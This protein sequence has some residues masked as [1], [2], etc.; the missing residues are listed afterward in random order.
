M[1][2]EIVKSERGVELRRHNEDGSITI[3]LCETPEAALFQA[4][5]L[6]YGRDPDP[7]RSILVGV[8]VKKDD[9]RITMAE[10]AEALKKKLAE[11][12][13]ILKP[14]DVNPFVGQ[15]LTVPYTQP[16]VYPDST[17]GPYVNPYV[18][19][20]GGSTITIIPTTWTTTTT[21]SVGSSSAT[22]T[23]NNGGA[24]GAVFGYAMASSDTVGYVAMNIASLKP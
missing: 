20:T 4:A 2:I 12:G 8:F 16:Y 5:S 15:P 14:A 11:D 1:K 6:L 13:I 10:Q 21:G 17:I 24:A 9:P 7:K 3:W 19:T 18:T 23:I 22:Y